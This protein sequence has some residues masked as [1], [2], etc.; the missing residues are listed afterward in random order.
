MSLQTPNQ[1]RLQ[2]TLLTL[3]LKRDA[4]DVCFQMGIHPDCPQF[5]CPL[6]VLFQMMVYDM[7]GEIHLV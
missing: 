1:D 5:K 3:E 6:E 2:P 4:G 7:Q